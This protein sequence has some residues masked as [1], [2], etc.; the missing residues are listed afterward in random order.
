M[1]LV[2]G[3][4]KLYSFGNNRHGQLGTMQ[5][6]NSQHSPVLINGPWKDEIGNKKFHTHKI[7]SGGNRNF[8]LLQSQK[9]FATIRKISIL[10]FHAIS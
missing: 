2:E 5:Q 4:G 3:N 10:K 6:A 7:V 8:I 9:V 1:A